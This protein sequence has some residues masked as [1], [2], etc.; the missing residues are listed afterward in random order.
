MKTAYKRIGTGRQLWR[1]VTIL[2]LGILL[3]GTAYGQ[4]TEEPYN[5]LFWQKYEIAL[6]DSLGRYET[7]KLLSHEQK[8]LIDAQA[9]QIT[10]LHEE[11][12]LLRLQSEIKVQELQAEIKR[13]RRRGRIEGAVIGAIIGVLIP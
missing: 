7:L 1:P 3:F 6:L 5:A 12:R 10:A 4:S 13:A 2:T 8:R 9:T 11:A